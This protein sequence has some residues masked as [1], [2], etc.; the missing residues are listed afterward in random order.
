MSAKIV[1]QT[2]KSMS[3]YTPLWARNKARNGD[4]ILSDAIN[5]NHSFERPWVAF[6]DRFPSRRDAA[7]AIQEALK[8]QGVEAQVRIGEGSAYL[9]SLAVQI[10]QSQ[11]EAFLN[12]CRRNRAA[13]ETIRASRP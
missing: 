10:P 8:K 9:Y 3:G 6:V 4:R 11:E 2:V 5:G 12:W 1:T 7:V 13:L